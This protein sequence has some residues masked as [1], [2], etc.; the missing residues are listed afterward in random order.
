MVCLLRCNSY[1]CLLLQQ[2]NALPI[3]YKYDVILPSFSGQFYPLSCHFG[4]NSDT[5][6]NQHRNFGKNLSP[7]IT[8]SVPIA[9]KQT[10]ACFP[11]ARLRFNQISK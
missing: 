1:F 11:T 2:I 10:I 3:I 6:K 7:S 8:K 4:T 5:S 9:E